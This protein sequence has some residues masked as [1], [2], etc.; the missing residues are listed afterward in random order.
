MCVQVQQ[1]ISY[2]T[3]TYMFYILH[4]AFNFI[5][6]CHNNNRPALLQE[7]EEWRDVAAYWKGIMRKH[8]ILIC[9]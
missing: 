9:F 3:Y 7:R 1:T 6:I 8:Y 2:I 4:M 5:F